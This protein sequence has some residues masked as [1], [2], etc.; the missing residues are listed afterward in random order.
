MTTTPDWHAADRAY[1][2]H[3]VNC[4]QCRSAGAAPGSSQ[5]CAAGAELWATYQ[6]AG[7]PPHFTWLAKRNTYRKPA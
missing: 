7:M 5:R 1:Q 3:H 4:P 2:L 6:A